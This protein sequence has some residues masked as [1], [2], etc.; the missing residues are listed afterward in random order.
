MF[1]KV[2][3]NATASLYLASGLVFSAAILLSNEKQTRTHNDNAI[4]VLP[5]LALGILS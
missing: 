4:K 5:K 2:P 1:F 3:T